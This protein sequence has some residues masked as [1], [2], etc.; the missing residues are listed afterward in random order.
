[1]RGS[2]R[3]WLVAASTNAA[4]AGIAG[5][6][7]ALDYA[8]SGALA[9]TDGTIDNAGGTRECARKTVAASGIHLPFAENFRAKVTARYSTLVHANEQI[10][11]PPGPTYAPR[12]RRNGHFKTTTRYGLPA[13]F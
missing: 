9:H 4:G 1:M 2:R 7:G 5:V 11:Y 6:T 8:L 13:R 10:G 12:D 3:G